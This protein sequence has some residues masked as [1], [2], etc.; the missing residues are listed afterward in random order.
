MIHFQKLR[1]S[2]VLHEFNLA[3]E[4]TVAIPLV[5]KFPGICSGPLLQDPKHPLLLLTSPPCSAMYWRMHLLKQTCV[6]GRFTF[7]K[8]RLT[9][10]RLKTHALMALKRTC[11]DANLMGS[12]AS[13]HTQGAR[14]ACLPRELIRQLFQPPNLQTK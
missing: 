12:A 4:P 3:T 10:P 13:T 7:I 8:Q 9:Q 5:R 14:G 1:I 6:G 2:H 11:S